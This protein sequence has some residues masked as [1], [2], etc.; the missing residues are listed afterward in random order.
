MIFGKGRHESRINSVSFKALIAPELPWWRQRIVQVSALSAAGV[1]VLCGLFIWYNGRALAAERVLEPDRVMSAAPEP[2]RIDPLLEEGENI[3]SSTKY[4]EK[5]TARAV[6]EE[7]VYR[8]FLILVNE[9]QAL[10]E[11]YEPEDLADVNEMAGQMDAAG[12]AVTKSGM[13]LNKTAAEALLAMVNAAQLEDG[14]GGWLLQ[15]GYRDFSY[16]S[17]LHQRKISEYRGSGYGEEDA[18]KA[19]AFWVARPRESEH[20]TGFAADISSRTHPDLQLTYANTVNGRWL[21]ENSWRFG[22]I[23]RYPEDK[24]DVTKVG[25]EPWHIRYTG[26]P[27]SGLITQKGWCLEEYIAHVRKEGGITFR[28]EDGAVW[29]VDYQPW[30]GD[31]IQAPAELPYTISGDGAGGFIITT[32]LEGPD[33]M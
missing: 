18:Q 16:Q 31:A 27:H 30:E 13:E 25:Y 7:D 29:Q 17:Y 21:A 24:S 5:T 20:H 32:R 3:R 9:N 4:R 8:G 33:S 23:I 19:A 6:A 12:F 15:S 22:F 28:D 26:L 1:L 14:L 11:S 10:P 2:G